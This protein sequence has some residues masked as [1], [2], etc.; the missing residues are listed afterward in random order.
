MDRGGCKFTVKALHAQQAGAIAVRA[1]ASRAPAT[2]APA[3]VRPRTLP[4]RPRGS[5]AVMVDDRVEGADNSLITMDSGADDQSQLCARS[6]APRPRT[7]EL[8]CGRQCPPTG[9]RLLTASSPLAPARPT[10]DAFT[11]RPL[12][13]PRRRRFLLRHAR[14]AAN[15]TIPIALIREDD[16]LILKTMLRKAKAGGL[17]ASL[18]YKRVLKRQTTQVPWGLWL[19]SDDS[20][21]VRCQN[22]LRLLADVRA[23]A[24]SMVA[25]CAALRTSRPL[26]SPG[27]PPP[28]A[29]TP[30][31]TERPAP[32]HARRSPAQEPRRLQ[33]P[34][35]RVPLPGARAQLRPPLH[36]RRAVLRPEPP[37]QGAS[38]VGARQLAASSGRDHLRRAPSFIIFCPV[39]S[40]YCRP[41]GG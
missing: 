6:L 16:G 11:R 19:T 36:Q 21:G 31:Q 18:D 14:E 8:L 22:Q 4:R 23:A 1:A 9:R 30:R 26:A 35:P 3:G 34:L 24:D 37:R 41:A 2:P 27:S 12:T 32:R 39:C 33:R 5:Q 7:C 28:P 17:P 29:S 20:C 38:A 25:E 15:V 13:S 10:D 40:L